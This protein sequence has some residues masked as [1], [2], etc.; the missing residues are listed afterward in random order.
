MTDVR[1]RFAPSPTGYLH[2]GGVRTA[3]YSWLWARQRGGTFVL[4]IEDTDADR[5]T[6]EAVQIV[7]DSMRWLG[8]DWDEG[9]EVGGAHGPY[10]QSER[11]DLYR[12]YADKLIRTGHAYRCYATKEEIAAARE[13][14]KQSGSKAGFRF[15]SPW[16]DRTEPPEDL[17]ARHVVR[18]RSPMAGSTAW[19]DLVKGRIEVPNDTQQ[20]FVLLRPNGLPLYNFG[21]VVDDLTMKITLVTRGDDHVVNTA[22]QILLYEALNATPPEFAHMPMVLAP[23]GE[24]L[25]KRHAAVG[26]LEYRDMGYLPDAVLNYLARLGW[27]H[28]DQEIFTRQELVDK[29]NWDKVGSTAGKYDAKKFIHVQAEHLRALSDQELAEQTVPFLAKIG[30]DV[31]AD[32]ATL[33]EAIPFVKTRAQT[34]VEMAQSLDYFFRDVVYE[35]K[36]KKKFLT[37]ESAP[38]LEELAN[39]VADVEP[40]DK[41][42]LGPKVKAWLEA[43]DLKMKVVA[44]PARVAMTGRTQS[45]GLFEVMQVLGKDETLKRLRAAAKIAVAAEL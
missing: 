9:P 41:D 1:A 35:D 10:V 27:S 17:N 42:T 23:N 36:G 22:P 45:P 44:Q 32:N 24:K 25:S 8:L 6:A 2:I 37:A 4:R 21:C 7:L 38:R 34:L 16:R 31:S 12:Q 15:V 13:A 26:V 29:F 33:L 20:D 5:S 28:G 39:V 43:N 30:V 11:L 3:L 19:V 18:F 14:H 40:F